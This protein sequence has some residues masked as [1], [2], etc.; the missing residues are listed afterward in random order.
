MRSAELCP[1]WLRWLVFIGCVSAVM[2]GIFR[3]VPPEMLFDN[4]D[5]VGH[6]IAFAAL[7]ITARLALPANRHGF[8]WPVLLVAAFVLEYLQGAWLPL[9]TFSLE[10]SYANSAG[11]AIGFAVCWLID[12]Y[13]S[14]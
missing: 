4:S 9:R 5:K 7:G 6:F 14:K 8:I 12:R 11:V 1:V 2:Y 10:D 13:R 3:P